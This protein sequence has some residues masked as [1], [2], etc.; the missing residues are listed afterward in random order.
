MNCAQAISRRQ[1]APNNM[2]TLRTITTTAR[3]GST[4]NDDALCIDTRRTRER[5]FTVIARCAL[6][7]CVCCYALP[8]WPAQNYPLKTVRVVVPFAPG[9]GIDLVARVVAQRLSESFGSSV[10]VDNRPGA[11]GVV[12][13]E[14]VARAAADGYTLLAVPISHAVNVSLYS[15]LS[16]DPIADFAPIAQ[17][18]SAPNIVLV[19]PSVPVSTVRE[20]VVLARA[21]PGELSYASGGNGSSTHLATELLKMLAKI[22]ILHVSYGGGGPA[23]IALIGGQVS[24]YFASLPASLP[25]V[26]SGKLKALAVTSAARA[27]IVPELPTV[28]EAGVPGY[29]YTGWYGMLAPAGTPAEIITR[30]NAEINTLLNAASVREK[31]AGDGAEPVGGTPDQFLVHLKSEIA[32]WAQVIKHA[33]L[34]IE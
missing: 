28:A 26:R 29:E 24:M 31:F 5:K 8:A 21:R 19:H 6:L 27:R 10:V 9:G 23:L 34:R 2:G 15:R 1:R 14:I 11:G 22:D 33:H 4:A 16:F 32:K 12:G 18:A 7:Y 25:H 20:L 13:S 30:L 17:L 3:C